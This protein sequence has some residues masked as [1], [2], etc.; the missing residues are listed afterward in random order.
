MKQLWDECLE[1]RLDPVIKGRI[2]G[3]KTQMTQYKVLFGLKLCERVLKITDN[4]SATLQNQSLPAAEAQSIAEMTIKTLEGMRSDEAFGLFLKLVECVRKSTDTEEPSLRK[5]KAPH[6]FEIGDGEGY[7]SLTVEEHY[8]TMYFEALDNAVS[9]IKER[10]D[11]PGYKIFK[12]LDGLLVKAANK[13]DYSAEF[14]E[15]IALYVTKFWKT[16]K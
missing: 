13:E 12:N 16:Y 5:R 2:I 15:V 9:A 7:H 14:Q 6:R 10:F 3:V 4:L 11:Q 1:K 8:R